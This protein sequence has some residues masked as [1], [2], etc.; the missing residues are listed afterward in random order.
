MVS[1]ISARRS[2][3][4]AIQADIFVV[5]DIRRLFRETIH[6]MHVPWGI[7]TSGDRAGVEK[8]LSS[9]GLSEDVTFVCKEAFTMPSPNLIFFWR[10]LSV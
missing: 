4:V 1:G 6:E 3:A 7:A 8:A 10:A 5:A 9:L 2:K